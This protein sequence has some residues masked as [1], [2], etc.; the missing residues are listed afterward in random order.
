MTDSDLH[1]LFCEWGA[2][3]RSRRLYAPS[4]NPQSVIGSLVRLPGGR[5]GN[6]RLDPMLAAL[7]MAILGAEGRDGQIVSIEYLWRPYSRPKVPVKRIASALGFSRQ[8]WYQLV[9]D[10]RRRVYAGVD[11]ISVAAPCQIPENVD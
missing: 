6:A 8:R 3:A 2:W 5:E 11:T 4:P 1:A 10:A 9:K 7:H